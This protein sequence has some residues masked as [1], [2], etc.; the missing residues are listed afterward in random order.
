M[1]DYILVLDV[2]TTSADIDTAKVV[3]IGAVKV[4]PGVCPLGE[5]VS[6]LVNPR[7][8]IPAEASAV[9]G[10]VYAD[11]WKEPAFGEVWRDSI[12]PLVDGAI[13]IVTYNGRNFDVPVLAR[14][15]VDAGLDHET[16]TKKPHIDV[17]VFVEWYH[18]AR[19]PRTLS[20]V[21]EGYGVPLGNAAHD[22][23]ADCV[24]TG[25]IL[26]SM[27]RDR[28]VS[29][30]PAAIAKSS[31]RLG[32]KI[33][34]EIERVG[35][36]MYFDRMSGDLTFGAGSINGMNVSEGV[37]F[38]PAQRAAVRRIIEHEETPELIGGQIEQYASS[39]DDW[40]R[41]GRFLITVD[42]N[43]CIALGE[44]WGGT[45]VFDVSPAY[46]RGLLERSGDE[47]TDECRAI[48]EPLASSREDWERFGHW[49]YNDQ[50][51]RLR[52]GCGKYATELL[53]KVKGG[54]I[55]WMIKASKNGVFDEP[56]PEEVVKCFG[57]ELGRR[58]RR[59]RRG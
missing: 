10:I 38:N 31:D 24:A 18:R 56:L 32:A 20:A 34:D 53:Y 22:A 9:H 44:R 11:V 47:M 42:G 4:A 19:R 5:P 3:Q 43:P 37:R 59:N 23:S 8:D 14:E 30:D 16:L 26:L 1:D 7:C 54:W 58:A 46:L 2:E 17:R 36:F 15:M 35:P 41:Y 33:D 55:D 45:H 57:A 6:V 21:A 39:K 51:R 12:A 28:L 25:R 50:K 40:R 49:L 52:L 27:I 13:A 29:G 48:I